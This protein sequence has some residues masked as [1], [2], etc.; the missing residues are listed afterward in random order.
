M[1]DRERLL[2]QLEVLDETQLDRLEDDDFFLQQARDELGAFIADFDRLV[3]QPEAEMPTVRSNLDFL[4][5]I[6]R[7]D[8]APRLREWFRPLDTGEDGVALDRGW[9]HHP[10]RTGPIGPEAAGVEWS[11][12]GHHVR[13]LAFNGTHATGWKVTV[14][15]VSLVGVEDSKFQ[16]RRY[17]DWAGLYAQLGLTMNWRTPVAT[18]P[19]P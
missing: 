8:I 6:V 15:G 18:P 3:S 2:D 10:E 19:A 12:E 11:F 16:I 5:A 14:R 17:V 4:V 7:A 1:A 9:R 13:D